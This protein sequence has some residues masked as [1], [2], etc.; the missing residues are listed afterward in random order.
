M[1]GTKATIFNAGEPIGNDADFNDCG[2]KLSINGQEFDGEV[3]DICPRIILV[4]AS[5]ITA[6]LL[7]ILAD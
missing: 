1:C 7:A 2:A 5:A 4:T 3:L 6:L